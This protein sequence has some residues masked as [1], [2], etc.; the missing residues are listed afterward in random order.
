[1]A[2]RAAGDQS[3]PIDQL[4]GSLNQDELVEGGALCR[5]G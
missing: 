3:Q 1:M 2:R 4:I 5:T